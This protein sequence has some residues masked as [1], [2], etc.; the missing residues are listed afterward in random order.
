M[1]VYVLD[2]AG[3]HVCMNFLSLWVCFG[4]CWF[5]GL[6]VLVECG[7][8]KEVWFY[9]VCFLDCVGSFWLSGCAC[10]YWVYLGCFSVH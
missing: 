7:G 5:M 6:Q 2:C 8:V 10:M 9:C 4:L 3:V 1:F